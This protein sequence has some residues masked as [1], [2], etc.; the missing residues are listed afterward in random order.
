MQRKASAVWTGGIKDGQ[1]HA[2]N[3]QRYPE[4][5]TIFLQHAV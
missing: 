2:L 5:D 4:A 3:R 1:G